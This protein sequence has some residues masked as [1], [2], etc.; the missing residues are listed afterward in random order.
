MSTEPPTP[1]PS[2]KIAL[3]GSK[4]ISETED[5]RRM[6]IVP[7][8]QSEFAQFDHLHNHGPL[9]DKISRSMLTGSRVTV[10]GWDTPC[11]GLNLNG[12]LISINVTN[13]HKRRKNAWGR[14]INVYLAYT[15]PDY[16]YKGYASRLIT[17]LEE[18]AI[19]GGCNR[20]KSLAG[21]WA[22]VRLHMHFGHTFWGIAKTGEIVVDSPLAPGMKFPDGIPEDV[23]N[24]TVEPAH[25]LTQSELYKILLTSERFKDS[26]EKEEKDLVE[27]LDG[28]F[29]RMR[30]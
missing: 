24:R 22:G 13:I 28:Y 16:R 18:T 27:I 14:Y 4:L 23:R 21:S 12:N 30:R 20:L 17:H 29:E 15:L 19:A 8:S 26:V 3:G 5:M 9:D 7:V 25:I 10:M 1:G 2:E 6:E 11:I